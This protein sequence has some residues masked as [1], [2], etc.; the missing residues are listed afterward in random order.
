MVSNIVI[1]NRGLFQGFDD[2]VS[3]KRPTYPAVIFD[4]I[5]ISATHINME[6]YG[7]PA[8]RF[9][10]FSVEIFKHLV[11]L[12]FLPGGDFSAFVECAECFPQ[13]L[14]VFCGGIFTVDLFVLRD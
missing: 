14:A 8:E 13:I 7:V 2:A 3:C 6:L 11:F 1:D 12:D 5:I 10:I 9:V 4:G